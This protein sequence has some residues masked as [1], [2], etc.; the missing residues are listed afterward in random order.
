MLKYQ[1]YQ[2]QLKGSTAYGKYYARVVSSETLGVSE[3]AEHMAAHNTP[4]S[5]GTI[6]GILSDAISCTKELLLE[7]KRVYWD[8]L[9][10]FGLS[11]EHNMGAATADEFTVAKNVKS[12]KL[13]ATGVGQFTKSVLTGDSSLKESKTYISPKSGYVPPTP[14]EPEPEPVYVTIQS[15]S[16]NANWGT[17]APESSNVLAGTDVVLTATAKSGYMFEKWSDGSTENPRTIVASEDA[18]FTANFKV[19]QELPPDGEDMPPIS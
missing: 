5:S 16:N 6:K 12:V 18:T 2:S 7:G 11:V 10:S 15:A 3:V 1:I 19:Y 13:V 9:A 14:V 17:V 8:N 4:F